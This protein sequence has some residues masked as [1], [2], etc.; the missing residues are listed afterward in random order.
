MNESAPDP[1]LHAET[2]LLLYLSSLLVVPAGA[3]WHAKVTQVT[4]IAYPDFQVCFCAYL[5]SPELPN[6]GADGSAEY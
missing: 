6:L 3:N 5:R 1:K 4:N 2:Q